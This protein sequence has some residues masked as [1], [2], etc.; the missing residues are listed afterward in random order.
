[1]LQRGDLTFTSDATSLAEQRLVLPNSAEDILLRLADYF[2]ASTAQSAL[3]SHFYYSLKELYSSLSP[4]LGGSP[5]VEDTL[6]A[7]RRFRQWEH[8][9][10]VNDPANDHSELQSSRVSYIPTPSKRDDPCPTPLSSFEPPSRNGQPPVGGG[11]LRY[12]LPRQPNRQIESFICSWN[13]S[14]RHWPTPMS[15]TIRRPEPVPMS[16]RTSLTPDGTG[17]RQPHGTWQTRWFRYRYT[18]QDAKRVGNVCRSCK[19]CAQSANCVN[20][21]WAWP[22]HRNKS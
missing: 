11:Q 16:S 22:N 21:V 19:L 5:A 1:M 4:S 14:P 8:L 15:A 17:H 2:P 13:K 18:L 6:Y 10:V 20:S 7:Y 12:G 3:P 9:D